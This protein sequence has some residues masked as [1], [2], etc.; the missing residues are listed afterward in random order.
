M[1]RHKSSQIFKKTN[2]PWPRFLYTCRP[3]VIC[4]RSWY[5]T[6][7]DYPLFLYLPF[8]HHH[9]LKSITFFFLYGEYP[10]A[11]L[12]IF[13][14][15]IKAKVSSD[16]YLKTLTWTIYII[17]HRSV[18]FIHAKVILNFLAFRLRPFDLW[19]VVTASSYSSLCFGESVL[20][21]TLAYTFLS[22]DYIIAQ[23][24]HNWN[25]QIAQNIQIFFVQRADFEHFAEFVLDILIKVWY[26]G[27]WRCVFERDYAQRHLLFYWSRARISEKCQVRS[28]KL[29]NFF[30]FAQKVFY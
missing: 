29:R 1:S 4:D 11:F 21:C 8:P 24:F 5:L 22:C 16:S 2:D 12:R 18:S 7:F 17:D 19:S 20:S 3:R 28:G 26:N 25:I 6:S 15:W 23:Y 9:T 30:R 27:K 13:E 10:Y 14:Y